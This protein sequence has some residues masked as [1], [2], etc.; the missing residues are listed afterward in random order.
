[1]LTANEIMSKVARVRLMNA[2]DRD[3]SFGYAKIDVTVVPKV[4][5]EIYTYH[6]HFNDKK[7]ELDYEEDITPESDEDLRQLR[8]MVKM[9]QYIYAILITKI[10]ESGE[11]E[12]QAFVNF[13]KGDHTK[14]VLNLSNIIIDEYI[15]FKDFKTVNDIINFVNKSELE[16]EQ[17]YQVVQDIRER[18]GKVW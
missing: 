4:K 13:D 18:F 12:S 16:T 8:K 1:M 9:P 17:E 2:I 3:K 10:L 15:K 11:K 14:A 6:F 7:P 5:D